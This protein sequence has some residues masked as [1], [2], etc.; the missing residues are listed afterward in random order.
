MDNNRKARNTKT[1]EYAVFLWIEGVVLE[2][3]IPPVDSQKLHPHHTLLPILF[4]MVTKHQQWRDTR[5][6]TDK[7]TELQLIYDLKPRGEHSV[8]KLCHTKLKPVPHFELLK[9]NN[10]NKKTGHIEQLKFFKIGRLRQRAFCSVGWDK[11]S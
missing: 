2:L 10:D 6:S 1:D 3:N 8:L 4:W 11:R 7:S 9:Q 5:P